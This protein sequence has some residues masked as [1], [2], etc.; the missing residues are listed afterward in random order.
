MWP[1]HALDF[2]LALTNYQRFGSANRDCGYQVKIA[3]CLGSFDDYRCGPYRR[4]KFREAALRN[5]SWARQQR[6]ALI[7]AKKAAADFNMT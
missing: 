5:W 2:R 1:S 6:I 3:A 4:A 7:P